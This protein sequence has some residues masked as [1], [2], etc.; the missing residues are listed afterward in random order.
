MPEEG[1]SQHG[2][3]KK[4]RLGGLKGTKKALGGERGAADGGSARAGGA[5]RGGK[6]DVVEEVKEETREEKAARRRAELDRELQRKA[7]AGPAKKKR[8][9]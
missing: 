6:A 4:G 7:A 2:P 8:K 5:G 1:G 3:S 9:F